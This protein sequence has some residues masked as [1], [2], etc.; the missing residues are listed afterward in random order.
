MIF[1]CHIR[2]HSVFEGFQ[3]ETLKVVRSLGIVKVLGQEGRIRSQFHYLPV[4]ELGDHLGVQGMYFSS[5]S[6]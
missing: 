4:V 1:V 6:T 3:G 2:P 5:A